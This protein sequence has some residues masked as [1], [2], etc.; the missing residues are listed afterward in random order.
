VD[1]SLAFP[2]NESSQVLKAHAKSFAW[3]AVFL[4]RQKRGPIARLYAF[5]RYID[6]LADDQAPEKAARDLKNLRAKVSEGSFDFSRELEGWGIQREWLLHLIDGALSDT[7]FEFFGSEDQLD[8]Y[9]YRVAGVVGLMMCPLLGVHDPKAWQAAVDLG[10][11]MQLTN[12][13]RDV[14]EDAKRARLYL[15]LPWLAEQGSSPNG[16]MEGFGVMAPVQRILVKADGL[17]ASGWRGLPYI[18]WRTRLSIAVA[19][20]IYRDIGRSLQQQFYDPFRQRAYVGRFR[21]IY[22][23]LK[24][25]MLAFSYKQRRFYAPI[26]HNLTWCQ[27]SVG[28]ATD[29]GTDHSAGRNDRTPH[30]DSPGESPGQQHLRL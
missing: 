22:L 2:L 12:I 27:A 25:V 14:E 8:L 28:T 1:T 21:K 10:S 9:C 16:V 24:A 5:C 17:Y 20:E 3:A 23:S 29:S 19:L 4:P 11:A 26:E 7:N 18:P 30:Q 13:A 15:P 6:D